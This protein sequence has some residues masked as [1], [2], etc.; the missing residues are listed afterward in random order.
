MAAGGTLT[1]RRT[2]PVLARFEPRPRLLRALNVPAIP[3]GLIDVLRFGRCADTSALASTGFSAITRP[4]IAFGPSS[5]RH[6]TRDEVRA[7][8]VGTGV[9]AWS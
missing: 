5:R 7:M 3:T 4:R 9:A 6:R 1:G 2:V 8:L